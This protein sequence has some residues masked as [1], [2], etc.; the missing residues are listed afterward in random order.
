M[1]FSLAQED[2]TGW[3]S[4]PWQAEWNRE[5]TEKEYSK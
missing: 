3:L 4:D 5:G 2:A 1:N